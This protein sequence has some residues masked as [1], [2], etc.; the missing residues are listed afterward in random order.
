MTLNERIAKVKGW[1]YFPARKSACPSRDFYQG[2]EKNW[3]GSIAD[4]WELVREIQAHNPGWRFSI[5]GGDT[6]FNGWKAEFFGHIDPSQDYGQR[7]ASEQAATL[8]EAICLAYLA[9]ME[10]KS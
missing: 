3:S 1:E 4:A 7:H 8:P 5:L 2:D 6:R 10:D 9:V